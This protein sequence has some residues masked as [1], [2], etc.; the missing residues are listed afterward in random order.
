MKRDKFSKRTVNFSNFYFILWPI[1]LSSGTV[2]FSTK[3]LLNAC[4]RIAPYFWSPQEFLQRVEKFRQSHF[5]VVIFS[6]L[7]PPARDEFF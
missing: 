3:G 1:E 7:D 6:N 4:G 2:G 5:R